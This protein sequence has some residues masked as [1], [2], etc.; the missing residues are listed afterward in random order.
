MCCL[1]INQYKTGSVNT[2]RYAYINDKQYH[3]DAP[4]INI[5]RFNCE[6]AM[7]VAVLN[8]IASLGGGRFPVLVLTFNGSWS[9]FS[10]SEYG[11]DIPW[12]L[13][14]AHINNKAIT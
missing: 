5:L 1:T 13:K 12:L 10:K 14:R 3:I 11:Y 2:S 9:Q 4:H 7:A 8:H 6:Q